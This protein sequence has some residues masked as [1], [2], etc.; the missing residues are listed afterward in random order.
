MVL[1]SAGVLSPPYHTWI[2]DCFES[3]EKLKNDWESMQY[4]HQ[5]HVSQTSFQC[6]DVMM[7][8]QNKMH[9]H[10]QG[11]SLCWKVLWF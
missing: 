5:N 7:P 3:T 8:T 2:S 10:S 4:E 11:Y 1:S 6:E 9:E